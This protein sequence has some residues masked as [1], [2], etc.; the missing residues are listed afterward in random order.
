MVLALV[1][2]ILWHPFT[3]FFVLFLTAMLGLREFYLILAPD[4]IKPQKVPGLIIAALTLLV[5]FLKNRGYSHAPGFELLIP[6]VIGI[7][8]IEMYRKKA[9]PFQNIAYTIFGL[10]YVSGP[11]ISLLFT[12]FPKTPGQY[13]PG[14]ALGFFI[15]LWSQDSG[16]YV[17]GMLM[18]RNPLF[19]RISPRK[20]V[21]GL[22]GGI[23]L[24]MLAASILARFIPLLNL[25]QWLI[26]ALLVAVFSTLGDLAESMLKRS[27]DI[28][29]SGNILPGHGGILDRFDGLLFAAP[30]FYYYLNINI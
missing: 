2:S 14:A 5:A 7:F 17:L 26:A 11:F 8:V 1:F 27:A 15:L 18:G 28:K 9:Y 29:D 19:R 23:A 13:A 16:A 22:I 24:S 20:T 12:A 6:A 21:E 10:L 3:Y 30:V 25:S 4:Y